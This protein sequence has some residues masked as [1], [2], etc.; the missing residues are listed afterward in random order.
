MLVEAGTVKEQEVH[1]RKC[2]VGK[3]GRSSCFSVNSDT[4]TIT[5]THTHTHSVA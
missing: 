5:H 2:R 4:H 1:A 3:F